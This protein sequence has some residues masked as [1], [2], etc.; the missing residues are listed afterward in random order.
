LGN[1]VLLIQSATQNRGVDVVVSQQSGAH[2]AG[3]MSILCDF[4]QFVDISGESSR[5][6]LPA[7]KTNVTLARI[8]I[9][10]VIQ[11][12]PGVVSK[13][14]QQG[15]KEYTLQG[16]SPLTVLPVTNLLASVNNIQTEQVV[17]SLSDESPVLM[18][19]PPSQELK[20]DSEAT[21]VL[22]GG[23]GALGLDIANWMVE[24]GAK[25]LVFLS[26]SGGSKN[27]QDLQKFAECSVRAEAFKCNV[28][29][30]ASVAKVFDTI[31]ASGRRIAGMI[32]LAMVLED[33]IF[34]NMSFNQWRH[35]TEP[36]TKGSRNLLANIWPGDKP[37]FI[38]LSS[39]TGVIGNTAQANYA[40][41]NTFEDALAHHAR[42][43]LGI[44]ATSIDVGLVSDSSHFTA[45]G[46]FG[47]LASYLGRYQ[48]GWRGLQTNLKELGVVMRAIMRGS[49]TNGQRVPA[50]VVLGLSDCIGHHESTGGF[51]KDKKF[52]LR[53]K[54]GNQA[55]DG[56]AKQDVG[57]LLSNATSMAEAAAV[58]EENI[59]DLVAAA[60]GVPLEE[61]DAQKPLYDYGGKSYV[62]PSL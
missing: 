28:N 26:R 29:D 36:K 57:T 3:A 41:G 40:S 1:F 50:Q 9:A 49:T 58:V 52:E 10:A 60:M 59:K 46:E 56:K 33:S 48:H 24:C 18:P 8:D 17:V 23:L 39:I 61:V 21:Y 7:S 53:V 38:L 37:F 47:D 5:A 27:Q 6:L 30:S 62:S 31:K 15:F 14:F 16:P 32:Q 55:R 45:A 20:L 11:G 22:A 42:T 51:S 44:S 13:L 54:V 25:N 4:G 35:A 19:A 34:D 43:H 12:R 2:V